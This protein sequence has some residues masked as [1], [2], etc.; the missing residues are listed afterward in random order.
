MPFNA[1][2]E[3][4][5]IA[6]TFVAFVTHMVAALMMLA[7]FT[8]LP[9][10]VFLTAPLPLAILAPIFFDLNDSIWRSYSNIGHLES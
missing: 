9:F 1:S 3:L 7:G 6:V 5:A 2:A 10:A 4:M 8:L